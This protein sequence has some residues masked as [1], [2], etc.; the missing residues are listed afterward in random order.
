[1]T[2]SPRRILRATRPRIPVL[3]VLQD[4]GDSGAEGSRVLHECRLLGP[5][6]AH[7]RARRQDDRA[8]QLRPRADK[9]GTAEVAFAVADEHQG[10]GI[11]TQLLQLLTNHAR[12]QGVRH[13]EAFV[14][15]ENRQMMRLFRNSGYELTRTIDEGVF[16]VDFP[17]AESEGMLRRSGSVRSGRSLP[18]SSPCSFFPR[19]V[20]VIGASTDPTSIGGRLFRNILNG[21]FTGPLYPVNPKAKVIGSVR[22]YPTIGEVPDEVD[23]A[24][25]VVP[26]AFVIDVARQCAASGVRGI[27]VISAG[28]SE[29]GEQGAKLE[30]ELSRSC[31]TR[32]CGWSGPTAW[33]CSTP[34]PR[35]S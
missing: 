25:I 26:Q 15:P 7:R 17:V 9:D 14:L 5:H 23:L 34:H 1:M 8:G 6:G 12:S 16:T 2:A 28:F 4:Q 3:P 10:R 31:G 24:Y 21:G 30:A 32:G 13:F 11:G 18:R 22:A 20:A 19:S 29:T 33:A 27:V 35:C